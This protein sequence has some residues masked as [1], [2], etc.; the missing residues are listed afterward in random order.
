M[1]LHHC[2]QIRQVA[3]RNIHTLFFDIFDTNTVG[4]VVQIQFD[5]RLSHIPQRHSQSY[6]QAIF[7]KTVFLYKAPAYCEHKKEKKL[8]FFHRACWSFP[9]KRLLNQSYYYPKIF[10]FYEKGIYVTIG[11]D[12]Y[13]SVNAQIHSVSGKPNGK[14]LQ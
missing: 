11:S 9:K 1:L 13:A 8:V 4:I 14:I 3:L 10:H 6:N 12:P 5:I 2:F 7:L